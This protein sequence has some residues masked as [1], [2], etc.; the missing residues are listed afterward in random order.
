MAARMVE[1]GVWLAFADPSRLPAELPAH[2]DGF[3]MIVLPAERAA[4]LEG[5]LEAFRNR[6]GVVAT[7]DNKQWGND[8]FIERI[9]LRGGLTL[10]HP[11][12]ARRMEQVSDEQLFRQSLRW[13]MG[14][15]GGAW[16]DVPRYYLEVL[17]GA[18]RLKREPALLDRAG[19]LVAELMKIRPIPLTDNA[20]LSCFY[21]ILE[22]QETTGRRDTVKLCVEV[23]DQYLAQAPR[24]RG[25]ISNFAAEGGI[26]RAET[27]FNLSNTLARLG[28]ILG[29]PRYLQ[30]AVEQLL[31]IDRELRDV[32]TGLWYVGRGAA[33]HAASL[34]GRGCAF[35]LR[36]V[37]DT[38]VEMPGSHPER[39]RLSAIVRTMAQSLRRFQ[40]PQGCWHQVLDEPVRPEPSATAWVTAALA[41]ARR[42]G[43]IDRQFA[44]TIQRGWQAVKR[45][46]WN[47]L[48][49]AHCPATTASLD[50]DYYRFSGFT[51]PSTFAHFPL[52]AAIEVLSLDC[53]GNSS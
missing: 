1:Q 45:Q 51:R 7:V 31:L 29:Q 25:V 35:S 19:G 42:Y 30:I 10:H 33:R 20:Q 22:Y 36:A 24:F 23:V 9:V 39:E 12:M 49:V 8:R 2:L 16:S 3:R 47:G 14:F 46:T 5:R 13:A 11:G 21:P 53:Q 6:G 52:L 4:K 27:A 44:S 50:P 37:L 40:D 34:W 26:V 38:L 28:R 17:L 18:Y 48:P 32:R 41:K 15:R 43:L